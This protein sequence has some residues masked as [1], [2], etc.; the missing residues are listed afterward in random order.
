M[1]TDLGKHDHGKKESKIKRKAFRYWAWRR[2]IPDFPKPHTVSGRWI[3][4]GLSRIFEICFSTQINFFVQVDLFL[5]LLW[6]PLCTVGFLC[7]LAAGHTISSGAA[8][9]TRSGLC[10]YPESAP[11][12]TYPQW[13]F[14]IRSTLSHLENI[15]KVMVPVFCCCCNLTTDIRWISECKISTTNNTWNANA[16]SRRASML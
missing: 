12:R 6:Q 15:I 1:S 8:G 10:A 4:M 7:D 16:A 5:S 9:A 11:C 3:A 2:T 14:K 13:I